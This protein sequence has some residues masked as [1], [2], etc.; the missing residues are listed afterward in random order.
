M[1]PASDLPYFFCLFEEEEMKS[2]GKQFYYVIH[3]AVPC[4]GGSRS[5]LRDI[6]SRTV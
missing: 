4:G 5:F 1:M 3:H 6:L 2:L